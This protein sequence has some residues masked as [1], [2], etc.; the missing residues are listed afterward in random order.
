MSSD[1]SISQIRREYGISNLSESSLKN[2]P[3]EQFKIWFD[4]ALKSDFPD[5]NAMVLSTASLNGMPSSR[6]V[7]LKHYDN[8]GLVFYT[9]YE[10]RKGK[11][12]SENPKASLLF[13]WDKLERQVRFNGRIEK[14]TSAESE[15]YFETRDYTSKLGA[16]ASR[17]SQT[18]PSRFTLMRNVVKIMAKYKNNVP[19]PEFWGGYRLIPEQIEFWQGR[20]SRLH[21]R[22]Q[23]DKTA[24]GWKVDRLY[25]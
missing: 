15:E 1:K 22:F 18:L 11:E 23:F 21:D 4:E 20:K 5:P 14:I 17:Q 16:W 8:R 6:V 12:L 19:L 10:S 2:D 9:N 13:F 25:P 3:L 7:L 24:D